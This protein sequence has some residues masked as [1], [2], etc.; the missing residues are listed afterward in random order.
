LK[1]LALPRE[2][3]SHP[4]TGKPIVAGFGRFGPYIANDGTYASLETPE[5]V[6]TV[7]LNRAVVLLAERKAKGG[8]GPRGGQALKELGAHPS[9]GAPVK[10]MKGKYGPYVTDGKL[11]ATL[12]RDSDPAS[13]TMEE[14]VALL[15]ARAEKEP[16]K[17]TKPKK[18]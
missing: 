4:E 1:L 5:D 9:S 12:P 10:V 7:G 17:K 2:I 6:F 8:R 16:S 11:N 3:G 15:A 14:A 18:A 13:V